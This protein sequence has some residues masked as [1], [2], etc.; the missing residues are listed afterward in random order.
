[1]AKKLPGWVSIG[2]R[3]IYARIDGKFVPIGWA[4]KE[5]FEPGEPHFVYEIARR[6]EE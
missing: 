1:M 6:N 2:Y 4:R 5:N 3:R